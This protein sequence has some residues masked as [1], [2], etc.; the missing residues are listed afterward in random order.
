MKKYID[1]HIN[2]LPSNLA[3]FLKFTTKIKIFEVLLNYERSLTGL[4]LLSGDLDN[5]KLSYA[6]MQKIDAFKCAD[7]LPRQA[8]MSILNQTG[9][10]RF[11]RRVFDSILKTNSIKAGSLTTV[12]VSIAAAKAALSTEE[13]RSLPPYDRASVV[14]QK[15]TKEF[16]NCWTSEGQIEEDI[17]KNRHPSLDKILHK[18][19]RI[20][21]P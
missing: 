4:L 6:A 2:D 19:D 8:A 15:V 3:N 1:N 13:V 16:G 21:S 7:K 20:E 18:F 10:F 12:Q 14:H 17:A 11:V 5:H 9:G